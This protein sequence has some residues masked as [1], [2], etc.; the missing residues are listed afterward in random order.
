MRQKT[1]H[2]IVQKV[3]SATKGVVAVVSEKEREKPP[4]T[5]LANHRKASPPGQGKEQKTPTKP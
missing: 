1:D 3:V 4:Q 5:R 2:Q